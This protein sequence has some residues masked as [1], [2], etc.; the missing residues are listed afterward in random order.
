MRDEI[1]VA[2]LVAELREAMGSPLGAAI[3]TPKDAWELLGAQMEPLLQEQVRVVALN[4][5]N[6]VIEV[7]LVYQGN[8][9]AAVIRMAELFRP[10]VLANAPA[11]LVVHNHP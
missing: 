2:Q 9:D 10:A 8:V 6:Q 1:R 7:S 4:T 3:F 11:I 5:R